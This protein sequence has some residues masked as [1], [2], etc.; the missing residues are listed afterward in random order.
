[1]SISPKTT[2]RGGRWGLKTIAT[3]IKQI[4]SICLKNSCVPPGNLSVLL[5]SMILQIYIYISQHVLRGNLFFTYN[6]SYSLFLN[7][8]AY[9]HLFYT[10]C[11]PFLQFR[12]S[13]F[14]YGIRFCHPTFDIEIRQLK[15]GAFHGLKFYKLNLFVHFSIF[16]KIYCK[17]VE[18]TEKNL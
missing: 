8:S 11:I 14:R 12:M 9:N 7:I 15:V 2:G 1:M 6:C 17:K 13:S 3:I 4:Y 5:I 18:S 10:K 16:L